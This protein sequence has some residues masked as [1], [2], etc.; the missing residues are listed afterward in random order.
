MDDKLQEQKVR[1]KRETSSMLLWIGF[2]I[3]ICTAI[4]AIFG[5]AAYGGGTGLALGVAF[6]IARRKRRNQQS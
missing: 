5:N 4:G 1:D 2:W 3:A 6:A